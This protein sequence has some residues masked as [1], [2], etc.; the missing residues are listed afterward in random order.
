[1]F[2]V[3]EKN[4]LSHIVPVVTLNTQPM[5]E[6]KTPVVVPNK[7][8]TT[9]N[10]ISELRTLVKSKFPPEYV[11]KMLHK[12]PDIPVV[13]NRASFLST[14]A[15]DEVVLDIGCTGMLSQGIK[16]V[17]KKYYGVDRQAGEWAV[18]DLDQSP[19][20][21]PYYEDVTLVICSEVLEHLSNPGRFLKVLAN[22][23]ANIPVCFT[24]P[25]AGAYNVRDG[26]EMVNIDHV[27]WY[28]YTTLKTLLGRCGFS[29]NDAAWYNGKPHRAEGIIM[30]AKA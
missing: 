3:V 27:S 29:V 13:E 9:V 26:C 23:Y 22:K 18:V 21:L 16:R 1:M 14:M 6:P 15:K 12:V 20:S 25:N 19:D 4:T 5:P 30:S 8:T 11:K 2:E 10:S 28:S 24:V 17:A 7:T